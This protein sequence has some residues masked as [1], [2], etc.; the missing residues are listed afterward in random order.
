MSKLRIGII[1][2][3]WGAMAHLSVWRSLPDVEVVGICTSRRE[4]AEAAA[5]QFGVPRAFWDAEAMAAAAEIDIVDCGT[6]PNIRHSMVLAALRSGKHVHN[7]VPFA[8]DIDQSRQLFET[9]QASDRVA[10]VDAFAQWLPAHRLAK[11]MFDDGF[12]GQLFAGTC[13]FNLGMFTP[14]NSQ[15]PYNW[16]WQG[17]FG[18]SA[19]RNLGSHALHLL[20]F[21]FGGLKSWL[22]TRA[23]CSTNGNSPRA[24]SSD[25]KPTI[26]PT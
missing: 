3:N 18:V 17:G 21:L 2:A 14:P 22:L 24:M 16:F 1:N 8:A 12:L 25:L 26:S 11:E 6:R 9:W 4:T 19:L 10:V 23:S 15:F 13:M 20:I 7:G 5:Q